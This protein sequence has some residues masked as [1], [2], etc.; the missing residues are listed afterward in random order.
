[1]SVLGWLGVRWHAGNGYG[2]ERRVVT[3]YQK[4]GRRRIGEVNRT[5]RGEREREF[6][7]FS[8]H[9]RKQR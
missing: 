8:K 4:E 9:K 1:M 6:L 7:I 5:R 3:P 2:Q